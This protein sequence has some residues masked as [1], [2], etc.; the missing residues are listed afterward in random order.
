MKRR[1]VPRGLEILL[2][3]ASVDPVF[4]GLLE[5][6]PERAA[7]SIDLILTDIERSILANVPPEGLR[8][9]IEKATVPRQ[10]V[11]TF[12]SHSAAAMLAVVL[13]TTVIVTAEG[14]A[15]AEPDYDEEQAYEA[16]ISDKLNVLQIALEAHHLERG[17]YPTTEDWYFRDNPLDGYVE[18]SYLS[19]PE[20]DRFRYRG[21]V[22]D[23]VVSG[24]RLGSINYD[25][26]EC[27][28]DPY[29]H[30]FPESPVVTITFPNSSGRKSARVRLEFGEENAAPLYLSAKHVEP[31]AVLT[32]YW[33]GSEVASGESTHAVQLMTNPGL[34]EL[35]VVDQMG[36]ADDLRI[37]VAQE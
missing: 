37:Y 26:I 15:G 9:M 20:G 11:S 33:D 3:K 12:L 17:H 32:W 23:G 4:R 1:I 24:Y 6:D 13:S 10:Y 36:E 28:N 2:K 31:E 18:Y 19:E 30:G 21:L 29:K 35:L 25:H 22:V 34:H 8:L 16:M 5:A 7:A 27:P 14:S